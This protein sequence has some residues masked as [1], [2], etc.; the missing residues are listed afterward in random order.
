VHEQQPLATDQPADQPAQPQLQASAPQQPDPQQPKVNKVLDNDGKERDFE[1]ICDQAIAM[2]KRR[3][4]LTYDAL[5]LKFG[6]NDE[7]LAVLKKEL[8][9][10]GQQVA[11]DEDDGVLV[12]KDPVS[13]QKPSWWKRLGIALKSWWKRNDIGYIW[14]VALLFAIGSGV[15]AWFVPREGSWFFL[16]LIWIHRIII[17][18]WTLA[19]A[20]WYLIDAQIRVKNNKPPTDAEKFFYDWAAKF[21]AAVLAALASIYLANGIWGQI[22]R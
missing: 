19:P 18:F 2:L 1:T 21:W 4:R 13:P 15:C 11:R 22:A 5:R 6:L 17:I 3:R 8:I 14:I 16:Q 20:T 12:W 7:Y 10:G 9:N